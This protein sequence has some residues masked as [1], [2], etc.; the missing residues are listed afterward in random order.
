[1]DMGVDMDMN[2]DMDMDGHIR[3][4]DVDLDME[5]D[6]DTDT[7]F[8]F[9][10]EKNSICLSSVLLFFAKLLCNG[11]RTCVESKPKLDDA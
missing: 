6:T 1:M 2:M 4:H 9:R 8:L 11:H 7:I 10:V 3:E 5:M